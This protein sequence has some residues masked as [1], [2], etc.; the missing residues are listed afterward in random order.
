MACEPYRDAIHKL[1]WKVI[2]V[3]E[4][5]L[6]NET[7]GASLRNIARYLKDKGRR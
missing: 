6:T 2:E 7:V 4:C 5:Q 1:G 3:W